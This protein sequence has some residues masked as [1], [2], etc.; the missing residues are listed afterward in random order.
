M[1]EKVKERLLNSAIFV[2]FSL[3]FVALSRAWLIRDVFVL[4]LGELS[5]N[6][7][8]GLKLATMVCVSGIFVINFYSF[9]LFRGLRQLLFSFIFLVLLIIV[10][11]A[12][13]VSVND[14]LPVTLLY[15]P[16]LQGIL[17]F[18]LL[19]V[20]GLLFLKLVLLRRPIHVDLPLGRIPFLLIGLVL[21]MIAGYFWIVKEPRLL[22]D[23]EIALLYILLFSNLIGYFMKYLIDGSSITG[24][25]LFV[26][27]VG[28]T[29]FFFKQSG[30]FSTGYEGVLESSF[31][32]IALVSLLNA[33]YRE[34]FT[35]Y[36]LEV[37]DLNQQRELYTENL[38]EVVE[39]R[40]LE[41]QKAN[42]QLESEIDAAR[43]LQQS[44]L[45]MKDIVYS[46]ASFVSENF[47]CE[48]LSGDFYDIY[49][50]DEDK[51]GMYIL[52]VSGH[53]INAALMN[54]YIYNY[55][56]TNSPLIKRLRGDQP[57]ENLRYLY[58]EF[59]K[60]NFPDHMHVVIFI[61][62]YDMKTGILS[63][64]SGGINVLPI[65][66][67]QSGGIEMLDESS[68]FPICK[69]ADYFTPEY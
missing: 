37:E 5:F 17:L 32:L 16:E 45:P 56:R 22:K 27:V 6:L 51:V 31:N 63:Y 64:A 50:I 38:K 59:N 24:N 34:L 52:D 66:V 18:F 42:E 53:G 8:I 28:S 30:I 69:M 61:A 11:L 15:R 20:M 47:P 60:M 14:S 23:M 43:R 26:L 46:R 68:G 13:V 9:S 41:L 62:S 65:L 29:S 49:S 2:L 40:T 48:R 19:V 57:H 67:R 7:Y 3:V 58:D 25:I 12:L 35:S 54:I 39:E 36:L 33:F 44:L 21:I 10:A 1:S 55:I 4:N